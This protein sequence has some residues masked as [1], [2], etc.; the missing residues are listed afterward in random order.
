[1]KNLVYRAHT[2]FVHGSQTDVLSSKIPA[3]RLCEGQSAIIADCS[4]RLLTDCGFVGGAIIC[5]LKNNRNGAI[6]LVNGRRFALCAHLCEKIFV[7][8]A[9]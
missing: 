8:A 5:V 7:N 3:A 9:K 2:R 4:D 6:F 1:M